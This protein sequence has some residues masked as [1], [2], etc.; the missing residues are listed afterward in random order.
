MKLLSRRQFL[1]T[2]LGMGLGSAAYARFI[3]PEWLEFSE[4]TVP[5][6]IYPE[7]DPL[8][9]L[10]LSDL[11]ASKLVSFEYLDNAIR[12][13]LTYRPDLICITGDF[14]SSEIPDID[15]YTLLL[16]KLSSAA[17][18]FAVFGNHD[19]GHWSARR[20]GAK[21]IS[22]IQDILLGSAIVPLVNRKQSLTIRGRD[23]VLAGLGDLWAG[24]F[25]PKT[26]FQESLAEEGKTII[27]LSHNPDT[28]DF[29]R[30]YHW[31]LMLSGHTHGGQI[32]IPLLGTPFAPVKD[33]RYVEGL[34]RWEKRWLHITR[35]VGNVR[36][37]R[38]NCRPQ[39]S[40][41]NLL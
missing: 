21:D 38:F 15:R 29:L 13:S 41:L 4:V 24:M 33:K 14:I 32:R 3:E 28:K 9:L 12:K 23:L 11:H 1:G 26:I 10:H 17:P 8:K 16:R 20:G 6:Q 18:T 7:N 34:H 22:G 40:L 2:L 35:G 27:L 30:K 36:G 39:V 5:L 25:S 37:L 19:G 31:H